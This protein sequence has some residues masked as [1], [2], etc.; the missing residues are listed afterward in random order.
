[1]YLAGTDSSKG[2]IGLVVIY[3]KEFESQVFYIDKAL[4]CLYCCLLQV[5]ILR[6]NFGPLEINL[7]LNDV[8]LRGHIGTHTRVRR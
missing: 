3:Q 7:G 2:G 8:L 1:M 6:Q 5:D 4:T